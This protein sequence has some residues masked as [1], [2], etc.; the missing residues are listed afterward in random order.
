[1]SQGFGVCNL[2]WKT[3]GNICCFLA[4]QHW[5]AV[6]RQKAPP[7]FSILVKKNIIFLGV[8]ST[9]DNRSGR[10]CQDGADFTVVVG[11]LFHGL[12]RE[13]KLKLY[14]NLTRFHAPPM[15]DEDQLWDREAKKLSA[16][17]LSWQEHSLHEAESFSAREP[18]SQTSALFLDVELDR[19]VSNEAVYKNTLHYRGSC[20]MCEEFPQNFSSFLLDLWYP[21]EIRSKTGLSK[22][23]DQNQK[24]KCI[25][26]GVEEQN[27]LNNCPVPIQLPEILTNFQFTWAL[28]LVHQRGELSQS[29][30]VHIAFVR[31]AGAPW[32]PCRRW[33]TDV[34]H[35]RGEAEL[36]RKWSRDPEVDSGLT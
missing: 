21:S 31:L 34:P 17:N 29:C 19:M 8:C 32:G 9:K 18:R 4:Q 28:G 24:Q 15:D 2:A 27:L 30:A 10:S 16:P 14:E 6:R 33:W 1:M 20:R 23:G 5:T 12:V 13:L 11:P 25:S 26:K 35:Q 7:H 3:Q 22:K 36:L